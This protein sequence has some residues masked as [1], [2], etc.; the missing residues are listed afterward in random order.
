MTNKTYGSLFSGG[1]LADVGAKDA[2]FTLLFANEWDAA[3]ADVYRANHG[4]HIRIGDILKQDPRDY[5]HVD[6]LHA[7]PTCT[8]FSASKTNVKETDNDIALAEKTAEFIRVLKPQSFTLENVSAYRHSHSYLIITNALVN[9]GY[10][11]HSKILNSADFGVPQTRRRLIVRAELGQF[12]NHLPA[13]MPWR[14]WYEATKDLI[15]GLPKSHKAKWQA[16]RLAKIKCGNIFAFDGA[17]SRNKNKNP[18]ITKREGYE[19]MFTITKSVHKG[20]VRIS[21]N[22]RVYASSPRFL[23][24]IQSLPDNYTLPE[25]KALA[26]AIIGNGVPCEMYRMIAENSGAYLT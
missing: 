24:R 9:A 1:G 11:Y 25:N 14:G 23:A 6:L 10:Y 4:D 17:N 13:P 16:E 3:V 20:S 18:K 12:V 26:V 8:N 19:P 7:S 15:D 22:G 2:G 21:V 5:P